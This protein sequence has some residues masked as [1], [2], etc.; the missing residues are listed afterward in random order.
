MSS[1]K[2]FNL[3]EY[4]GG[5]RDYQRHLLRRMESR[6]DESRI[7]IVAPPGSGKIALGLELVRRIGAS[8]IILSS[9]STMQHHWGENFIAHFLPEEEKACADQYV[10]YRLD[11]PALITTVTYQD[12]SEI[13]L[14]QKAHD[15]A[16][17]KAAEAADKVGETYV[18]APFEGVNMVHLVQQYNIGTILLDEAHHLDSNWQSALETFLGVLGGEITVVSM[19][20]TPPYDL[21]EESWNRYISLCGEISDEICVPELVKGGILCPHQDFVYFTSPVADEAAGILGYRLRADEAAKK[22]AELRFMS[23]LNRRVTK[24]FN[25]HSGYVYSHR[26]PVVDL[27]K[28]LHEYG[29]M[30]NMSLYKQLTG[31]TRVEPLTLEDAQHAYNFLLESQT[32]LRDN[33]KDQLIRVF[34]DHRVMEHNH[35]QLTTTDKIRHT[36]VSSV[37]K[38]S[39]I[40]SIARSESRA[41]ETDFRGIVMIDS[42]HEG[43]LGQLGGHHA[44][45]SVNMCTTFNALHKE[46]PE[47][48]VGCLMSQGIVLPAEV[49]AILRAKGIGEKDCT[50]VPSSVGG[51]ALFSF[52]PDIHAVSAVTDLFRDGHIRILI[53]CAKDL[54]E[55]WDDSFVNTL[56]LPAFSHSFNESNRMRGRV[57]HTDPAHPDKVAHIWHIVTVEQAYDLKSEPTLRLASRMSEPGRGINSA[58]Y[59]MLRRQFECFMGPNEATGEL[60]NG[61]D[62]LS[63]IRPPYDSEGLKQ[64]NEKMLGKVEQR[65]KTD[66]LW[67]E[68]MVENTRPISEVRVPEIAKVPVLTGMNVFLLLLAAVCIIVGISQ[69]PTVILF[70]YLA[71]LMT[72]DIFWVVVILLIINIAAIVW[73]IAFVV[74]MVP[75]LVNHLFALTSLRSLCKVLVK[76]LKDLGVISK[77]AELVMESM[78]DR[79]SLRVY[80]DNCSHS[81]QI[82][83]HKAVAEL[84]GPIDSPRYIMVRAGWFKR[85]LWRWSFACPAVIGKTD[86]AVKMFAKN[87]RMSMG[88]MKF[89]YTRRELGRKY[90]MYAQNYSYINNYHVTCE[91]RLHLLKH[92][93]K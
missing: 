4:R 82:E 47:L 88:T 17:K 63:S 29:H 64:I 44:P 22:A 25:K 56:I 71:F 69:L 48:P 6:M 2:S 62:R 67:Q 93:R 73:G 27:F 55:G 51:Y 87:M 33:E 81:E 21:S 50:V 57:I 43:D 59:Y 85:L 60:E 12:L 1:S 3:V 41:L 5:F 19:T 24:I 46:L 92:D 78:T 84:L 9:T 7:N 68:A 32:I 42:H 75:L 89:Q 16:E 18:N 20:S 35:V 15:E 39:G 31:R 13:V 77:D 30:V 91:K 10:S 79:N 11:S 40:V 36:I 70:S 23:E 37:S 52:A 90:L 74:Y 8:C 76:T 26:T 49:E 80:L 86:V 83:F 28:L 38:L 66:E 65:K 72:P 61:I 14:A 54:G 45:N 58:D 53:G 34:T